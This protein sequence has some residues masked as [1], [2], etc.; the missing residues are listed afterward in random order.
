M[1]QWIG[2]ALTIIGLLLNKPIMPQNSLPTV[3]TNPA[4]VQTPPEQR[5]F[6]YTNL[7]VAFDTQTGKYY[8]QHADGQWYD[9]LP[10]P[11]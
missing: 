1:L 7:H 11:F 6:L 3:Q 4:P 8:F 2:I 10:K 9:F 5:R